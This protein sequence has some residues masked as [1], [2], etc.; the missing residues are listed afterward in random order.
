MTKSRFYVNLQKARPCHSSGVILLMP[1][2]N[3]IVL[4]M[5]FVV[6]EVTVSTPFSRN[7]DF[8]LPFIILPMLRTH[9]S[10]GTGTVGPFEAAVSRD[11]FLPHSYNLITKTCTSCTCKVYLKYF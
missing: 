4:H 3:P 8:L 11:S 7:F 1:G 2:F 5:R 6:E 9:L 10:S